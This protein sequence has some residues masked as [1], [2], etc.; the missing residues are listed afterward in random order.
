MTYVPGQ[1]VRISSRSHGGHH[2]TPS[3]AKGRTGIVVRLH[4]SF[5]NPETRAY[6]HDGLP[7]RE[8]YLVELAGD[9]GGGTICVDVF[10]HWLESVE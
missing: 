3:Y 2:R 1:P 9:T 7:T 4:G 6:G 10:E 8:L 5:S